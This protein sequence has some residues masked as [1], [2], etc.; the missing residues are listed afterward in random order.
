MNISL[1]MTNPLPPDN[2]PY[3]SL[4]RTSEAIKA[5]VQS[6][7]QYPD[8]YPNAHDDLT[9]DILCATCRTGG[10]VKNVDPLNLG[11][12]TLAQAPET[13]RSYLWDVPTLQRNHRC[14]L[15][16][17]VWRTFQPFYEK[18]EKSGAPVAVLGYNEGKKHGEPRWIETLAMVFRKTLDHQD[19]RESGQV[20]S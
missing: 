2:R 15:C 3:G 1:K 19:I 6:L 10:N 12:G 13:G 18:L 5:P 4:F 20:V 11:D 9:E 17:L 16:R 8:G 14:S 7:L